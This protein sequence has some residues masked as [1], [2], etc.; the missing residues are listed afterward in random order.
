MLTAE[1]L[2]NFL[3]EVFPNNQMEIVSVSEE[4]VTVKQR[5]TARHLRPGGTVAGPVL[6]GL[7]DASVYL[8]LLS[9]IGLIALA[10]T[11]NFNINFLR[12]PEEKDVIAVASI[13]K[14]GKRLAIGEITMYSEGN[15]EPVAHATCTYSIPGK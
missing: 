15:S 13:L 4:N 12:K 5:I 3:D 10:V 6:M 9:K 2:Q 11:T 1:V 8:A 7:A 14:L